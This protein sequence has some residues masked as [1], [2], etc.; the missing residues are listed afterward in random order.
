MTRILLVTDYFLRKQRTGLD[1]YCDELAYWLPRLAP[2]IE[3]TLVSFGEE[4]VQHDWFTSNITHVGLP[5]SRRN[6]ML[7]ALLHTSNPLREL[8][9]SVDL[10]HAL[11]PLPLTSPK[12]L[13]VTVH[14]LITLLFPQHYPWHNR[15]IT[16]W[17][18]GRL[19]RQNSRFIA[20]SNCTGSDLARLMQIPSSRITTV[21]N[22]VNPIYSPTR[23]PQKIGQV[24]IKYRLPERYFLYIGSMHPRKNLKTL[25][26]AYPIFKRDD[27]ENIGLVVAGRMSLGGDAL[28]QY[29]QEQNLHHAITLPGYI[30]EADLP[31]VIRGAE[32][33]IYP[34]LY[35]GFGL[36]ALEAMAC[37]TP[38]IAS[39]SSS[40]PEATGEHA[41]L[42]N[43]LDT[44]CFVDAMRAITQNQELRDKLRVNGREWSGQ[45]SWQSSAAQ[46]VRLYAGL[47]KDFPI[48]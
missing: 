48:E 36:P 32:A 14:D 13:L 42:C 22:G 23:D 47:I 41:L 27:T 16:R 17:I 44:S 21:Y 10:V 7:S 5:V 24:R 29:L 12:P 25:L 1:R 38:V 30:E 4:S 43:P 2:D 34:S 35:E 11:L 20:V 45:F 37:G 8:L 15:F 39:K 28:L 18:L 40:I 33:M 6:F 26:A 9:A 19:V 3:F 31:D 46:V